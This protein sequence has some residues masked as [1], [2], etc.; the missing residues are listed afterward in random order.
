[1]DKKV[2]S[3]QI[4]MLIRE[5]YSK[6]TN[7][8][9]DSL[10]GNGLTHQQIIIIKL[11]GHNKEMTISDICTE[12]SLSKGT[13]SGIVS[14]LEAAGYVKKYK[15]GSDKRNTYI[16][17]SDKGYEFALKCKDKMTEG[18]DRIF[19]EFTETEIEEIKISLTKMLSKIK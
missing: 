14:R 10:K 4:A 19:E 17:L 7:I 8:I 11:I 3:F 5:V 6:T 18:F 15:I 12:M 13:I 2:D 16:M 9:A 1:M